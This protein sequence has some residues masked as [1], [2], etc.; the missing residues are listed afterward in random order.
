MLRRRR[1]LDEIG[2][3]FEPAPELTI[4]DPEV[5]RVLADPLRLRL[6]QHNLGK[7]WTVKDAARALGISQTKLYYHVNLLETHGLIRVH[8][9]RVVSGIIEKS[10]RITAYS[11]RPDKSLL[12]AGA[13]DSQIPE[14]LGS[15]IDNARDNLTAA[16]RAGLIDAS[17]ATEGD[18][19]LLIQNGF[20]ALTPERAE[21]LRK[22]L[23]AVMEDFAAAAPGTPG[24]QT[25]SFVLLLHRVPQDTS[26]ANNEEEES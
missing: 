25:Y 26:P 7:P 11:F 3:E 24:T 5:L 13:M 21:D 2:T 6:V 23:V 18:R 1:T 8:S 15:V 9:T 17:P 20:V 22:R 16:L 4:T 19:K 10:Y 12:T 14:L